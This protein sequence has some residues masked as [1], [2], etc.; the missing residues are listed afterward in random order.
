MR[1]ADQ[2]V[3]MSGICALLNRS[4]SPILLGGLVSA[5][6]LQ[7]DLATTLTGYFPGFSPETVVKERFQQAG[8][9]ID[10]KQPDC[11]QVHNEA[12]YGRLVREG[13]MGLGESYMDGWWDAAAVDGLIFRLLRTHLD[14]EAT[15]TAPQAFTWLYA[16]LFN[17]QTRDGSHKVIDLHYQLGNDLFGR[18]L[19]PTMAYSCGYWKDAKNLHEAQ[20]A[21]FDLIARKLDLKP[22]MHVLDIG[23]GWGGFAKHIASK[24]GATVVGITLSEDQAQIA[25]QRCKGLPVEIRLMDYRDVNS[26]FDRV[27]EIGMFEHV[28][29][30]NYRIFMETVHRNLKEGG[31]FMLHTIGGN[32]STAGG[33]AWIDRYI[34]P[35]G[36]LPSIAQIGKSIEG[37]FV[38]EDWHNFGTDYDKTLMAW[39][40]NFNAHWP[41][42][43]ASYP[44]PFFRMWNYY[45]LS[46]AGAFRARAIQLWQVVLSKGGVLG[47]YES[48]R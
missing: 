32:Q 29:P 27:V 1:I 9:P 43:Q 14:E 7:A 26:Q 3:A 45:L 42:I 40:Q 36:H 16:H 31:L 30:K 10:G 8:V 11:P 41:E 17:P 34:F 28:G 37:L 23:C 19:D 24:Y 13:S 12:F 39:H 48:V 33:D 4:V 21:K 44:D 22:G 5:S 2:L 25:R 18:M 15:W 47:G 38:M 6:W 20:L 46:C 35:G